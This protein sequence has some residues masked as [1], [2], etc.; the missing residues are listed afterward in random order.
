[1]SGAPVLT[2][3]LVTLQLQDQ[4]ESLPPVQAGHAFWSDPDFVSA[5]VSS[6][7]A[8]I[9]PPGTPYPRPLPYSV[10]GVAGFGRG[11]ANSSP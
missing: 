1:M 5:L 9:A 4:S 11:A 6:G 2:V 10:R 8:E 3:A 7:Q